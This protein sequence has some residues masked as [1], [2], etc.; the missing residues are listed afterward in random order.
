ME[1]EDDED[2]S[3]SKSAKSTKS[4]KAKA[5]DKEKEKEKKW[6]APQSEKEDDDPPFA[7]TASW[8]SSL[9]PSLPTLSSHAGSA[10]V[11]LSVLASQSSQSQSQSQSQAPGL[12]LTPM[13]LSMPTTY[14]SSA[15]PYAA[16]ATRPFAAPAP[17]PPPFSSPALVPNLSREKEE[18]APT[19]TSH[20]TTT[21]ITTE[22]AP[23][24]QGSIPPT[25]QPTN[26]KSMH[27]RHNRH[28]RNH[29][30]RTLLNSP[31]FACA[32]RRRK[33]RWRRR[34]GRGRGRWLGCC[35]M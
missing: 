16:T 13:S 29:L 5:E 34:R 2:F 22:T 26:L 15:A 3:P 21:T 9:P 4:K 23:L 32:L 17:T 11:P 7:T 33:C 8:V 14:A 25:P 10:A 20:A 27:N 12:I 1:D 18:I 30:F 6:Q 31:T 24:N 19:A 28:R 35:W